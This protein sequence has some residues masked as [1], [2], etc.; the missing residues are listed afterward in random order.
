MD[1]NDTDVK[2]IVKNIGFQINAQKKLAMKWQE[3]CE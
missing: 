1:L 2:K 3:F